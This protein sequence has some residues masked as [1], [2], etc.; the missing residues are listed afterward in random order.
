M[1]IRVTANLRDLPPDL[2]THPLVDAVGI[3]PSD[4]L[5]ALWQTAT[6]VFY[7]STVEA[8]GYPLAEARAYGVP[9]IAPDTAQAREIAGAALRGYDPV[10]PHGLGAALRAAA[11]PVTSEPAGFDRDSYFD[12][13]L[14]RSPAA[15]PDTAGVRL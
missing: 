8:F 1:P 2:A 11:E 6:A 4:R 15:V 5:A 10:D 3:M 14:G 9:V 12:W 7:P 13:L